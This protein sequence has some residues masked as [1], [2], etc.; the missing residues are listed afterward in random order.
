MMVTDPKPWGAQGFVAIPVERGKVPSEAYYRAKWEEMEFIGRAE[1]M[2]RDVN[3]ARM[4][5][6]DAQYQGEVADGKQGA[7]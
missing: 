1:F 3:E 4:E 5:A 2:P 6:E 7:F